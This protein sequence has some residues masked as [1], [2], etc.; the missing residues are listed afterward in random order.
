MVIA[1]MNRRK[2]IQ[3]LATGGILI[4]TGCALSNNSD[5]NTASPPLQRIRIVNLHDDNVRISVEIRGE[6]KKLDFSN[7]V[8]PISDGISEEWV[9]KPRGIDNAFDYSYIIRIENG[10]TSTVSSQTLSKMF[11]AMDDGCLELTWLIREP[12]DD[13]GA[14]P[15]IINQCAD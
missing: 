8:D 9:V 5:N 3:G 12:S 1:K 15:Q 14:F 11:E 6:E 10:D 7:T 13:I 4:T 2:I